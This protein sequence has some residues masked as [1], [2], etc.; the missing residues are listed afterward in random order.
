MRITRRFAGF[1]LIESMIASVVLAACAVGMCGVL[2]ASAQN[3]EE[4]DASTA[5]VDAARLNLENLAAKRLANISSAN[6]AATTETINSAYLNNSVARTEASGTIAYKQRN[7]AQGAR[8]I[9][10]VSV[11]VQSDTGQEITLHQI[12]TRAEVHR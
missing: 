9:A 11:T 1:T 8:D 4:I 5:C 2:M 7:G 10:I 6:G 3:S 12:L